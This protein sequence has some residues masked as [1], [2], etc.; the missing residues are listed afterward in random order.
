MT[1]L[2]RWSEAEAT[3]LAAQATAEAQETPRLLW[4]IHAALGQLYRAQRRHAKAKRAFTAARKVIEKM[5]ATIPDA[6]LR[7]N[8]LRQATARFPY[9]QSATPL[10]AAKQAS[11]GLTRRERQVAALIAEGKS[12]KEIAQALFISERTVEG[13]VSNTLTRLN[14]TARTQIAAWA[15]ETELTKD[16][17][18]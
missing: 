9:K 6:T 15:V 10:Q 5:A 13:H 2:H 17:S 3:L 11:G 4:P 14:V 1:A 12:N 16:D 8:F 7:D 18:L